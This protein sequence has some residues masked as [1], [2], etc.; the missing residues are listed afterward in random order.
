[1]AVGDRHAVVHT[2][3]TVE[4]RRLRLANGNRGYD[5]DQIAIH[6]G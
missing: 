5:E 6:D 3:G 1:M 4:D 2:G